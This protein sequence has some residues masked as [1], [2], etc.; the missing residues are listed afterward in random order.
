MGWKTA[1]TVVRG[2]S[3]EDLAKAGYTPDGGTSTPDEAIA[4]GLGDHLSVVV[5]GDDLVLIGRGTDPDLTGT[6]H[7]ALG[8]EVA[9]AFFMS[10][11]DYYTW[12]VAHAGGRR[13]WS[14]GEGEVVVDEG[15]PLPEE[16][17]L[18]VLDERGLRRLLEARTG[19]RL[20]DLATGTAQSLA[21]GSPVP[22]R[23]KRRWFGRG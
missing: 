12:T 10:T 20:A 6:L 22:E 1:L 7:T 2:A 8:V 19:L 5:H 9:H 4:E 23:R 14:C 16:G 3:V 13:S 18:R 15:D 17:T 11:V 21:F